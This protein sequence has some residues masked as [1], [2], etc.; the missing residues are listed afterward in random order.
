MIPQL[1]HQM[2]VQRNCHQQCQRSIC[3]FILLCPCLL[4]PRCGVHESA[5]QQINCSGKHDTQS[6]TNPPKCEILSFAA[7]LMK[8][9]DI[10]LLSEIIQAQINSTCFHLYEEVKID[11]AILSEPE[12]SVGEMGMQ[13]A[14]LLVTKS[15]VKFLGKIIS[16]LVQN[17]IEAIVN[18]NYYKKSLHGRV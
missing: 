10:C 11:K 4:Q 13:T 5:H 6:L 8:Q 18:S 9:E 15:M 14:Q 12:K 17:N 1:Y 2:H 7:T 16:D 3:A